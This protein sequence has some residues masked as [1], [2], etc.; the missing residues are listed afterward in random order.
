[1]KIYKFEFD[2]TDWVAGPNKQAIVE[3]YLNHTGMGLSDLMEMDIQSVPRDE[4]KDGVIVDIESYDE[5]GEHP[6]IETFEDY[7]LRM[8]PHTVEII[9]TT[10]Y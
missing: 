3:W 9:A 8:E 5:N 10:G 6:V 4:W 7:V 1:M 2:N